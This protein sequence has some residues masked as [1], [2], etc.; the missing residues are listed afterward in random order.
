LHQLARHQWGWP[1]RPTPSSTLLLV[2][3]RALRERG[4][5]RLRRISPYRRLPDAQ[6]TLSRRPR[7]GS[8]LSV[9]SG[10]PLCDGRP[11][12][13]HAPWRDRRRLRS[14]VSDVS[15]E[16][17]TLQ[18]IAEHLASAVAP[19][20]EAFREV[21][22]FRALMLRL[23]YEVDGLPPAYTN[24]ADQALAAV[25]A[26]TALADGAE[27]E[28]IVALLRSV[29]AVYE[30]VDALT[31]A[32]PG[33]DA[34]EFLPEIARNLFEYLLA[35]YLQTEHPAVH[36]ALELLGVIHFEDVPGSGSRPGFVRTRFEWERIPEMLSDPARI[37]EEVFGWGTDDFDFG[38]VA[39]IL[40]E[41]ALGL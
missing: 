2:G 3:R 5:L 24:V 12:R 34:A 36:S 28:E 8:R 39:E 15:D 35:E 17:G 29:G 22:A 40:S 11:D 4:W 20:D 6:P 38:K 18:L 7:T 1:A 31:Q 26:A 30:S 41:L 25:S 19:L 16:N 9:L 13:P 14:Q 33:V 23:G 32:P 21:D 27:L 10:L 37:P